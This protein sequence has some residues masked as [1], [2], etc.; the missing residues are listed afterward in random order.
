[1]VENNS[2]FQQLN[3]ISDDNVSESAVPKWKVI[4][5][6]AIIFLAIIASAY[7][8]FIKDNFAEEEIYFVAP[9]DDTVILDDKLVGMDLGIV[10]LYDESNELPEI[11]NEAVLETASEA[12]SKGVRTVIIRLHPTDNRYTEM[13]DMYE[14][15]DAPAILMFGRYEMMKFAKDE[16]TEEALMKAYQFVTTNSSI[17][18]EKE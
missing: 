18:D 13:L 8:L 17:G 1:M 10:I 3:V 16:I 2:D 14:M 5:F 11:M 12:K 15:E 9:I 7:S 4:I 6:I